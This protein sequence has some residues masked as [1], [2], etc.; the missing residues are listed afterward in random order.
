[1]SISSMVRTSDAVFAASVA[2][3]SLEEWADFRRVCLIRSTA[4]KSNAA[5]V[6]PS[7]E[8]K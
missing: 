3:V 6:S 5:L 1:M 4:M 2:H 8:K 7:S